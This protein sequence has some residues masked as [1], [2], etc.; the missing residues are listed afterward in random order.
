MIRRRNPPLAGG[1]VVENGGRASRSIERFFCRT[2]GQ[3]VEEATV[4]GGSFR[5][6]RCLRQDLHQ[7]RGNRLRGPLPPLPS[8]GPIRNRPWWDRLPFLHCLLSRS[9]LLGMLRAKAAFWCLSPMKVMSFFVACAIW[10]NGGRGV[11]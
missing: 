3:R 2:T 10:G 1:G 5:V 8:P 6:L 4:S 11:A 9:A 7:S